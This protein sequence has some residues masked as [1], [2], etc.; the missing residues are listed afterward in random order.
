MYY[1]LAARRR[2]S[3]AQRCKNYGYPIM[4]EY[5]CSRFAWLQSMSSPWQT[6]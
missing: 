2:T 6:L 3:E 1:V 5:E 4:I